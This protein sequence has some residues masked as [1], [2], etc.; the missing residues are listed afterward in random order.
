V[1]QTRYNFKESGYADANFFIDRE[2]WHMVARISNDNLWR[3]TYGELP[4]LTDR[5]LLARQRHKFQ[6]F[7]PGHPSPESKAYEVVTISPFCIH[8]RLAERMR[9][10]RILLAADAAL[11]KSSCAAAE[12]SLVPD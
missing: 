12:Q 5:E 9:V 11:R 3:V 6:A 8:Q 4:G 7:L 2:H 10:G 1:S